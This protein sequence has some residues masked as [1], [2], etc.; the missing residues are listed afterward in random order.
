MQGLVSAVGRMIETCRPC[1]LRK[2]PVTRSPASPRW[3]ISQTEA[4]VLGMP[5]SLGDFPP[6]MGKVI[7]TA[8]T[9][10][11]EAISA[12]GGNSRSLVT[13]MNEV[14]LGDAGR[15]EALSVGVNVRAT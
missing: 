6:T 4:T 3:P 8:D 11:M 15:G 7:L 2:V 12:A 1:Q 5:L 13:H 10:H 9:Q 14:S